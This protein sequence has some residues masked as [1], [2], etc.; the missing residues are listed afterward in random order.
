MEKSSKYPVPVIFSA[1]S[2]LLFFSIFVQYTLKRG[3]VWY[4]QD[5]DQFILSRCKVGNGALLLLWLILFLIGMGKWIGGSVFFLIVEM[6]W[7]VLFLLLGLGTLLIL[8]E[9]SFQLLQI[10]QTPLQKKQM[11]FSFLPF[12]TDWLR[13]SRKQ[14]DKPY[15]WNKE[16]QIRWFGIVLALFFSPSIMVGGVL[17][18]LLIMRIGLLMF[19][20]D[21]LSQQQKI[22]LHRLFKIYPEESFSMLI[23]QMKKLFNPYL[24]QPLL[25]RYQESYGLFPTKKEKLI[26]FIVYLVV[27]W[28]FAFRIRYGGLRWKSSVLW[29][30]IIRLLILK[31]N[32]IS[33]PKLPIIA[34]LTLAH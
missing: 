2:G 19:G 30:M 9:V 17:V 31:K 32:N 25:V 15:W 22:W 5:A 8:S 12:Y 33:V 24:D 26:N 34:E 14:F 23:I 4:S 21:I 13:F 20:Y 18:L 11:L 29:W 6:L 28:L 1:L 7:Y 27:Y 16:A 10:Q 3:K